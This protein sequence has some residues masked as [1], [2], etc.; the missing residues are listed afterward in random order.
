MASK[1]LQ[2]HLFADDTNIIYSDKNPKKLEFIIN[3]ELARLQERFTANELT[4]NI[5]SQSTVTSPYSWEFFSSNVFFWCGVAQDQLVS[6]KT[7]FGS[8]KSP[9]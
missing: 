7:R 1:V 8:L 3:S 6:N 4:I 2:F 9:H 5:K